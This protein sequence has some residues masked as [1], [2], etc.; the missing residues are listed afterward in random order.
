MSVQCNFHF[1]L[2]D[3]HDISSDL[4]GT[5]KR[6]EFDYLIR[7]KDILNNCTQKIKVLEISAFD[8]QGLQDVAKWV[9]EHSP[10]N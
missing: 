10:A 6:T 8:G 1:L 3:I 4:P 7:L 5:M 9:Q 2:A